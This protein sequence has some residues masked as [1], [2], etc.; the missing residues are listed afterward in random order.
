MFMVVKLF[1]KT[2]NPTMGFL[3]LW[4]ELKLWLVPN[5]IN[6]TRD[7]NS[8]HM[9]NN[10][11][12]TGSYNATDK[13]A[14]AVSRGNEYPG[15]ESGNDCYQEVKHHF[16]DSAKAEN[17]PGDSGHNQLLFPALRELKVYLSIHRKTIK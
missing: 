8:E 9:D 13:I 3:F 12:D 14:S 1:E 15:E 16:A 6:E 4:M 10:A 2:K 7:G 5:I 17:N 11:D